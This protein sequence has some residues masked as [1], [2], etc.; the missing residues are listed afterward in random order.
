MVEAVPQLCTIGRIC[1][2]GTGCVATAT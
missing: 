1:N 2:S